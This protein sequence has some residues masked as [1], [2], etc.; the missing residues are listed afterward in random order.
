[1]TNDLDLRNYLGEH[2]SRCANEIKSVGLRK[3]VYA[4]L[5]CTTV[6]HSDTHTHFVCVF[7]GLA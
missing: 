1:L 3:N 2:G 7:S 4:V 6:V 5:L